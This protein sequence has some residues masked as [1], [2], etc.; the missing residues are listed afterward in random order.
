M[1]IDSDQQRAADPADVAFNLHRAAVA[2][3]AGVT[4]KAARAPV[5]SIAVTKR[6]PY[7]SRAS[8]TVVIEE[9]DCLHGQLD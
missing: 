8:H 7:F 1:N 2:V 5:L 9:L 6:S 4:A 3:T